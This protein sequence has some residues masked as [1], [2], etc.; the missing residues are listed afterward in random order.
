V[1]HANGAG[2]PD[3]VDASDNEPCAIILAEVL[4]ALRQIWRENFLVRPKNLP[5]DSF[6]E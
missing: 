3:T 5:G 6:M 1:E 4:T 2:N